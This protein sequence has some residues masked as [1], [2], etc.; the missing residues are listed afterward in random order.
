[1]VVVEKKSVNFCRKGQMKKVL[2]N[3]LQ[4][5]SNSMTLM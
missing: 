4:E 1:M 2:N 3:V 5:F